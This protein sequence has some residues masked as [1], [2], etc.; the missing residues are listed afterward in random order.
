MRPF[1]PSPRDTPNAI[2]AAAMQLFGVVRVSP[3]MTYSAQMILKATPER[4]HLIRR[5][6]KLKE[7]LRLTTDGMTRDSIQAEIAALK[8]WVAPTDR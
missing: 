8:L 3:P 5:R 1:A 7:L 6:D 4:E 2:F